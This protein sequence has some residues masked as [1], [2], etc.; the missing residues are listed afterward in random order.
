M[1][2]WQRRGREG[3]KKERMGWE[4][5]VNGGYN[6]GGRDEGRKERIVSSLILFQGRDQFIFSDIHMM[7]S[8]W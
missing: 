7:V 6:K 5:D 1:A 8:C 4:R 2:L 3:K